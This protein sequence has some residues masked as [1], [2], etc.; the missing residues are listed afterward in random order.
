MEKFT[1]GTLAK[2]AQVNIE[3]I[4]FYERK[5][6]LPPPER[7]ASGYR[8][9]SREDVKR[10]RFII[11]AKSHGFTLN[12]IKEL[13]N[14]RVDPH[15]TCSEVRQKAEAKIEYIETKIR[16]LLRIKKALQELAKSC[17]GE[18][19]AGECPILDAFEQE[20]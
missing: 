4:R 11:M 2:T 7:K 19:P 9:Y 16:E 14:L 18:G 13:L 3:T 12:E 17:H 15:S 1:I 10:L 6:L 20:A 8:L 5:G